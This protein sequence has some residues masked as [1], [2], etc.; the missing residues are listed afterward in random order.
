MKITVKSFSLMVFSLLAMTSQA[1]QTNNYLKFNNKDLIAH[2]K[3]KAETTFLSENTITGRLL[4]I[5]KG[6]KRNEVLEYDKVYYIID[7]KCKL[8][9]G[10]L[11]VPISQG[12]IVFVPRESLDSFYDVE[13]PLHAIE[14]ASL[15]NKSVKDTLSLS[16][17]LDEIARTRKPNDDVWND[18]LKRK[19]MIFGLYMLPKPVNGD[20]ALTHKWD[21][22]NLVT[23]GS[24]KFQVGDQV[25]D[26]KAGDIIYVKKG[27]PHFFH[28]LQ[29][30]LDILIFF[31]MRS[32]QH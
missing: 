20:Q 5:G 15:E 4:Y 27:N 2:Q 19:S 23:N 17:S 21:E 11:D 3:H 7:G 10:N 26:V 22:V 1:Q 9:A 31:E 12:S 32:L 8:K 25:M 13:V 6:Q 29:Q 18:F 28:S 30:D 24:G 14:L 16:F